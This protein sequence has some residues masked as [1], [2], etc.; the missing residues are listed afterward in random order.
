MENFLNI[1]Q[2]INANADKKIVK[3]SRNPFLGIVL[4]LAGA[5]CTVL[6]MKI[7]MG[8]ALK[9][10]ILTLGI[11]IIII[12]MILIIICFSKD[13]GYYV[14]TPTGSRMKSY[15][16]YINANDKQRC[17][18][19]L[20]TG[21]V[22]VLDHITPEVSTSTLVNILLAKDKSCTVLQLDEYI[23]HEFM[24]VTEVLI[25][26]DNSDTAKVEA[27]IDKKY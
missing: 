7:A 26:T 18:D 12:G 3:K 9:M 5:A 23:P 25:L 20:A 21:K 6:S 27:F 15:K 2:Y 19:G 17:R 13:S 10:A 11:F 14:Y 8:D 22:D 16:R 1:E 4:L 24:P